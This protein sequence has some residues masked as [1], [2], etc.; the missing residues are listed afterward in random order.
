MRSRKVIVALSIM[1]I[2][3][4]IAVCPIATADA[5]DESDV[6]LICKSDQ[7]EIESSYNYTLYVVITNNLEYQEN[8]S[9]SNQRWISI[10]VEP[11]D[12]VTGVVSENNFMLAGQE[13]KELTITLTADRYSASGTFDL[14]VSLNIS[15][16]DSDDTTVVYNEY[17]FQMT[18]SSSLDDG[19]SY[20]KIIGIFVNPLP[21]PFNSPLATAVISFFITLIIGM[22]IIMIV[23]PILMKVIFH[24]YTKEERKKY[25]RSLEKFL[26][27]IAILYSI[28]LSLAIYGAPVDVISTFKT[29]SYVLYIF[30]GATIAWNLY[31]AFITYTLTRIHNEIVLGDVDDL[32]PDE[33]SD[34]EPLFHLIGKIIISLVAV[35]AILTSFGLDMGAVITSAGLV[36]LGIT[37]GAQSVLNQ[38]FSGIVLLTT[39]PFKTGDLVQVGTSEK[40]YKVKK[41]SV[42]NTTFE[43]WANEDVII[44]PND[45][46]ASS[47]IT[48]L[49]GKSLIYKI[50]VFMTV[51]YG[52]DLDKAKKI[53]LDIG[54]THP[55][56]IIDGSVEL[57]YVRVTAFQDSAIQVRL[58]VYVNDYNNYS[59]IGSELSEEIYKKF[60]EEGIN[61]PYPQMDVHVDYVHNSG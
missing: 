8:P 34:L 39:R 14:V 13:T 3:A 7:I 51:A 11:V 45:S 58:T 24:G 43:N 1:A 50:H 54:R 31:K 36:T 41:V 44:M 56:V 38:F 61:I 47:A 42:M 48:N 49:T 35:A 2:L 15:S 25:R 59:K 19:E 18:V 57:P 12:S 52:T 40:T 28:D 37:W 46:V 23:A 16:L 21:S 33:P 20:N 30:L 22:I 27:L 26:S 60:M 53:M 32:Y 5:T 10:T 9:L 55:E 17:T 6:S 29:W 4:T